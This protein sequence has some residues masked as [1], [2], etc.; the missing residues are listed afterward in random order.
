[1]SVRYRGS[2]F[3]YAVRTNELTLFFLLQVPGPECENFISVG[4]WGEQTLARLIINNNKV[5]VIKG[6]QRQQHKVELRSTN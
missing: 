6:Q 4:D 1:M 2:S 5:S 3:S